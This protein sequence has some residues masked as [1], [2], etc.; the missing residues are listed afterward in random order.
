MLSPPATLAD[1]GA[2]LAGLKAGVQAERAA[3]QARFR[4]TADGTLVLREH[5]RLVDRVLKEMWRQLRLPAPLALL[6]V[7]GYGRGEL[8]PHSDVDV[9]VLLQDPASAGLAGQIEKLVGRLWDAGLELAHSVRTVAECVEEA[10]KDVTVMTSLLEAR[11]VAGNRGLFARFDRARR[12]CLDP[13]VFFKAKRLEQEQRHT[14]FQDSPYSL[15]PNLKEAP[16]GLR[17]LQVILWIS[18]ACGLGSS[19]TELA[20]RALVTREEARQVQ[21]HHRFLQNLR[22]R[23]HYA[24]GRREDRLLFDY[25]DSPARELGYSPTAHRRAGEQLMQSYFRTAKAVTQL[26]TILLQ[27]MGAE[28]FPARNSDGA[29]ISEKFR[30]VGELLEAHRADLFER[31]PTAI[32]ES[33]LVMQQHSELKGMTAQTLRALWRA[34]TRIDAAF[35]RDLRNRAIFLSLLQQPRGIVHELRRMN[36]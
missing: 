11:Q 35:R 20:Q 22:V 33:F 1:G 32:L 27:N 14:K 31:E 12:N 25:Q 6:A 30:R 8:Y 4:E 15:E 17:D 9:L 23:L 36:Q 10:R 7:G 3:L 21:R 18:Q 5:R 34:R 28:I 24:A 2:T 19:W 13:E 16:G 29:K 26:N